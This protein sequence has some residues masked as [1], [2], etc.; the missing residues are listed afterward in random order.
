MITEVEIEI[1][2]ASNAAVCDNTDS[3]SFGGTQNATIQPEVIQAGLDAIAE[4]HHM[5]IQGDVTERVLGG[6]YAVT[7]QR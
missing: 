1:V 2:A 4:G 3:Y 5:D 6:G 7:G